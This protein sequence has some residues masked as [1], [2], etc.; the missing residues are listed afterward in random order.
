[1]GTRVVSCSE[2][3]STVSHLLVF[4]FIYIHTIPRQHYLADNNV[5]A[6]YVGRLSNDTTADELYKYHVDEGLKGCLSEAA[7]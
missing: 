5:L 3:S 4:L 1:M 2:A 7:T 6:D